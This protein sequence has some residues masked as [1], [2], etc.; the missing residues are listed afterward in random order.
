MLYNQTLLN[1]NANTSVVSAFNE[2]P[3]DFH[4]SKIN[5]IINSGLL[6]LSTKNGSDKFKV[7]IDNDSEL[8]NRGINK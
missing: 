4:W 8:E 3:E 2:N 1:L 7:A 6:L 5:F